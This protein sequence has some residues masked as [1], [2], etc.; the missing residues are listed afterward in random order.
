[1]ARPQA[2]LFALTLTVCVAAAA[3]HLP[4]AQQTSTTVGPVAVTA[5]AVPMNPENPSQRE[6]GRFTYAGGLELTAAAG[7]RF[8]GLSDLDVDDKGQIL[9]VTDEGA[10]ISTA[11]ILD[12]GERL[13]GIAGV[14]SA[15]LAGLDG[16]PLRDKAVADAEGLASM[17]NGDRLVSFEREHRIWRYPSG[18]GRP[19]TVPTPPTADLPLNSGMEGLTSAPPL[20]RDV[21]LVGSEGGRIWLC[22]LA[23][24][25]RETAL[26][27]FV[28]ESFGL[29]G[30]AVSPDGSV[31]ALATRAFDPSRG[32]RVRVRLL[33]RSALDDRAAP[34][35]D[36][37]VLEAPLTRD[38]VEGLAL[39]PGRNGS[40]RLYLL[41][42]NNFS[43]TQHTYLLAFDWTARAR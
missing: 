18:G 43:D 24:A 10:W 22:G 7:V 3:T 6:V 32:V 39:R 15:P 8:G 33:P 41:S 4:Y 34:P 31:L 36:D 38:N 28:P 20:G 27:S 30:I 11:L 35:L 40:L 26:G 42:D 37:L 23:T 25:C 17:P 13:T 9:S 21:Y 5:T 29:T 16:E 2:Y 1:M 14:T 19:V 12:E